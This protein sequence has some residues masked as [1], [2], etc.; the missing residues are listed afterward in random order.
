MPL[1]AFPFRLAPWVLAGALALGL[2]ACGG[3][4]GGDGTPSST[5][6]GSRGQVALMV[7]DAPSDDFAHIN[8]TV[9]SV[10]LLG[11][12]GTQA[13]TLYSGEKTFDLLAMHSHAELF[14]LT[15]IP[16]GRYEKIRLT[17][18]DV[19]L[20]REDANGAVVER[21]HPKLPA[22][23]KLDLNPRGAIDVNADETL[24]LQLDMDAKKSIHIVET[25]KGEYRFRPVVFVD[26]LGTGVPGKLVRIEGDVQNVN[27][28]TQ[29]FDLC[30]QDAGMPAPEP[31]CFHVQADSDTALFNAQGDAVQFGELRN[32]GKATV[33][34]R[35]V[36]RADENSALTFDADV[37]ELGPPGTFTQL[38]GEVRTLA[39]DRSSFVLQVAPKQGFAPGTT[40]QVVLHDETRVFTRDGA[41]LEQVQVGDE[42]RVEGVVVL[43]DINGDRMKAAL[44]YVHADAEADEPVSGTLAQF[45]ATNTGFILATAEGDR[46]VT[47]ADKAHVFEVSLAPGGLVSEAVTLAQLETGQRV[48]VYGP[49]GVGGCYLARHVIATAP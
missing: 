5:S 26:V 31:R 49:M 25:G 41:A 9:T 16:A 7:T 48:D 45:N 42:V 8:V 36:P 22:N 30:H 46:C 19:E 32:G 17:V 14:G 2:S 39:A 4:D 1:I 27:P 23:G 18:T 6:G 37:V 12:D 13:Q 21:I 44:V 29:R 11:E 10:Q 15:E 3:G 47:L 35:F 24:L 33:L 40:L 34:G 43:S 20:V 28:Q 38:K